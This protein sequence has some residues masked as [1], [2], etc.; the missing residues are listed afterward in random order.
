MHVQCNP[1]D[2]VALAEQQDIRS[3]KHK[4][5]YDCPHLTAEM[6]MQIFVKHEEEEKPTLS[7]MQCFKINILVS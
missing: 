5:K 2:N 7:N 4:Y 3:C 1:I 6:Q